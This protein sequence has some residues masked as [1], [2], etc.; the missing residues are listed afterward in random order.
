MLIDVLMATRKKGGWG[1]EQLKQAL[2]AIKV[3]GLKIKP[4]AIKYSIP[5]KTLSDYIRRGTID[6][7][8]TGPETIFSQE[9]ELVLVNRIKR[10]Q[11]VG[12]PLTRDDIRRTAYQYGCTVCVAERFGKSGPVTNRAGRDWFDAFMARHADLSFRSTETLSYGRGAGLNRSIVQEFYDLLTKTV[13]NYGIQPHNIFNMDETGLQLCTRSTN[14]VA[15][16]GSKRVPQMSSG[17]KGETIS[18]MACCSA[19]GVFLPP[20]IIFKGKRRKEELADGLPPGTEFHMTESGYAQ[21]ATFRQFVQFF[22]KHKP[23][24]KSLLIMDGHKSHVD[25]EALSIADANDITV[26]LLP[27][28]TSHELQPL[29]KSVFKA[30]KS[31]FYSQCKTWHSTHPGR[32]F[33]KSTFHQVFTPAWNKAASR[34]NAISGFTSTGIYPVNRCAISDSAFGPADV[35]DRALEAPIEPAENPVEPAGVQE[36]SA[37]PSLEMDV[38]AVCESGSNDIL[39]VPDESDNDNRSFS[40]GCYP[41]TSTPSAAAGCALPDSNCKEPEKRETSFV[42][43]LSTPKIKRKAVKRR[44]TNSHAVLL[45]KDAVELESR[46]TPK[47]KNVATKLQFTSDGHKPKS[48]KQTCRQDKGKRPPAFPTPPRMKKQKKRANEIRCSGCKIAENSSEDRALGQDWVKCVCSLWW[49][50]DCGE[51][52]GIF[53]DEYFTCPLC[54]A[55]Q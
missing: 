8:R 15:E 28:H 1:D 24:G 13:E 11:Q 32:S 7:R 30:L 26:L 31:A 6:K 47:T 34:E 3:D 53:D 49:H 2:N 37:E 55:K 18:V 33:T 19:T 54:I 12:F 46:K 40:D 25:Y 21:T 5:R 16:K 36:P 50:E 4:A 42:S 29:D 39:A 44:S 14:V 52:G 35:S 9:E 10:L 43:L 20:F 27:A 38:E 51:Q 22:S 41:T 23:A 45:N 17:E 48:R